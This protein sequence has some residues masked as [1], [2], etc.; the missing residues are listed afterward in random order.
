MAAAE[1]TKPRPVLNWGPTI[2]FNA[3]LPALTYFVLAG[4]GFTEVSALLA[5]SLW[6]LFELG[7]SFALHRRVDELSV[8]VLVL[9]GLS[10][11][12][13]LGFNSPRLL[14]VKE[15]AVTG[16]FGLAILASYAVP[17]PLMFYFGRKFATNGT[18]EGIAWWNGLWQYPGFRRTQ[19]IINCPPARWWSSRPCCRWSCSAR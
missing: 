10:M 7:L 13:A 3:V 15:S 16:L 5:S 17:R 18:P 14:L 11:L 6:P 4:H 8:L 1:T 12:A 19:R 9:L 2:L